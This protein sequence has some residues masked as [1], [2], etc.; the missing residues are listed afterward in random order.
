MRDEGR[1]QHEENE[2]ERREADRRGDERLRMGKI[3]RATPRVSGLGW[4]GDSDAWTVHVPLGPRQGSVTRA[5]YEV[6]HSRPALG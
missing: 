4:A 2:S 6:R 5:A 1:G 3:S